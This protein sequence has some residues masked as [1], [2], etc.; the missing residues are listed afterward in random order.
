MNSLV[1]G[2]VWQHVQNRQW[3][4]AEKMTEVEIMRKRVTE[5]QQTTSWGMLGFLSWSVWQSSVNVLQCENAVFSSGIRKAKLIFTTGAGADLSVV[6]SSTADSRGLNSSG[7]GLVVS[8]IVEWC[9]VEHN[10]C[11]Q[12]QNI[13]SAKK[14][15]NN[16][17]LKTSLEFQ[18]FAVISAQ[19]LS[20]ISQKVKQLILKD[21]HHH[22]GCHF[23]AHATSFSVFQPYIKMESYIF[24]FVSEVISIYY[25]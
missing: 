15:N 20:L 8:F 7:V 18:H 17:N 21:H 24:S 5:C 12:I 22:M 14:K 2:S 6:L 9:G 11:K 25:Y 4:L 16:N 3:R 19:T 23:R 10:K 1:G 13:K